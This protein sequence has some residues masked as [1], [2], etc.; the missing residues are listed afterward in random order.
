MTSPRAQADVVIVGSGP[1]GAAFARTIAD[2]WP[3]ARIC[4]LEAGPLVS[5]PPGHHVA[6][7]RDPA[8]Q[9]AARLSSQG[10]ARGTVHLPT[11]EDEWKERIAG[12]PEASMLRRPGLF[13]VGRG[14]IDGPGFPAGHASSN[15]GGMGAHWFGGCPRRRS[16]LEKRP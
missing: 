7:I 2:K 11:T 14:D 15:V 3:E 13:T 4:M 6:N 16:L 10:P 1:T 12:R 9:I 8:A 5:D